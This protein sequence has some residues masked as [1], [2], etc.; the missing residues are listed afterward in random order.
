MN[1]PN[2]S[3]ALP[4]H[5]LTEQQAAMLEF[6]GAPED[7]YYL[8]TEVFRLEGELDVAALRSAVRLLVERHGMA[9]ARFDHRLPTYR[10]EDFAP[11]V[12]DSM[13][14]DAGAL[15]GAEEGLASAM[16]WLRRP[17]RLAEEPPLRLYVARCGSTEW[18]FGASGHH[19]V[20]DGWSFKLVWDELSA[21]YRALRSGNVPALKPASQ[22][23]DSS[24]VRRTDQRDEDWSAEFGRRYGAVRA[25]QERAASPLGPARR[26]YATVADDLDA[27][28]VAKARALATTPYALG[29]AAMLRAM[30]EV[31]GDDQV[32]F[33]TAFAGR[34]N[35]AAVRTVGY[36]STSIFIGADLAVHAT[37]EALLDHVKQTVARW[38][39]GGRRQWEQVLAAYDARDL[40]P[41][42]FSFQP[43][44]MVQ[45]EPVFEGLTVQRI[46][47]PSGT[48]AR[49][50]LD[51]AVHYGGGE[52]DVD[53]AFREDALDLGEVR[54]LV[55]AFVGHLRKLCG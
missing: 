30:A 40:Y 54:R 43:A 14:H 37:D 17:L 13:L 3:G 23:A 51:L 31:M 19:L 11:S 55:D 34:V 27:L 15:P 7:A 21:A 35:G 28:V 42:K 52:L 16:A 46:K 20:F 41:V 38:Q 22:Y 4:E 18:V 6:I 33:G 26:E 9:R 1:T 44:A 32:I 47:P 25:L 45:P 10:I 8:V 48:R 29:C 49:R 36:F 5:A 50:P 53:A 39:A 24:A 2:V 12:A